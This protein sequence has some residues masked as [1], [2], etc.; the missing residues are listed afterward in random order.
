MGPRLKKFNRQ[1]SQ[2]YLIYI[3][4]ISETILLITIIFLIA[5]NSVKYGKYP[6]Y[7]IVFV[8]VEPAVVILPVVVTFYILLCQKLNLASRKL[9]STT[10]FFCL[11]MLV[12]CAVLQTGLTW[13]FICSNYT[14]DYCNIQAPNDSEDDYKQYQA[15]LAA[16]TQLFGRA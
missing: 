14:K 3:L 10:R 11:I 6:I 4:G 1:S 8:Y 15:A 9:Y 5:F 2:L 13:S 12:I 16:Q 7:K